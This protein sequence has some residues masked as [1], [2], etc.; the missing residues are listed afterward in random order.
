M[1]VKWWSVLTRKSGLPH[2]HRHIS[3]RFPFHPSRWNCWVQIKATTAKSHDLLSVNIFS[4]YEAL[5]Y[6]NRSRPRKANGQA[7]YHLYPPPVRQK[8]F[9]RTTPIDDLLQKRVFPGVM[10]FRPSEAK[11]ERNYS[12]APSLGATEKW[13][14]AIASLWRNIITRVNI[15]HQRQ[16]IALISSPEFKFKK[17]V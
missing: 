7:S 10:I 15:R 16:L 6:S 12:V 1:K 8:I 4:N 11:A 14:S 9:R 3:G 17:C 13:L 2:L 5:L